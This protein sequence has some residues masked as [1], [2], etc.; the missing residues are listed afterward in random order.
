MA[1]KSPNSKPRD[2]IVKGEYTPL[3]KRKKSSRVILPSIKV[4][5]G[6][7]L[8]D[9]KAEQFAKKVSKVLKNQN[10]NKRKVRASYTSPFHTQMQEEIV[11][12]KKL[13]DVSKAHGYTPKIAKMRKIANLLRDELEARYDEKPD[14]NVVRLGDLAIDRTGN[15][16]KLV[17]LTDEE[18]EEERRFC[19]GVVADNMPGCLSI[20]PKQILGSKGIMIGSTEQGITERDFSIIEPLIEELKPEELVMTTSIELYTGLG[21]TGM[22]KVLL[23]PRLQ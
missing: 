3:P 7:R 13:V 21:R 23:D 5:K 16:Q 11:N 9:E 19:A 17:I 15:R 14:A 12:Q 18:Q 4:V 8:E 20:N 1:K 22:E 10:G 6:F 2:N